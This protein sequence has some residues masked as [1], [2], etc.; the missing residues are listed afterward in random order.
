MFPCGIKLACFANN[1]GSVKLYD[2]QFLK[3]VLQSAR[4]F[5]VDMRTKNHAPEFLILLAL[6]IF[7]IPSFSNSLYAA[8]REVYCIIGKT[9]L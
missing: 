7:L 4:F 5:V 1:Q 9:S 2:A 3:K 8:S 6:V